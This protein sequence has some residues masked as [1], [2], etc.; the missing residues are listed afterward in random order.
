MKPMLMMKLLMSRE[1]VYAP[2]CV[3][4][5]ERSHVPPRMMPRLSKNAW[6]E[7]QDTYRRKNPTARIDTIAR[8]TIACY[9]FSPVMKSLKNSM[10]ALT[11]REDGC[12]SS[13]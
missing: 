3:R 9:V 7:T 4:K 5:N 11:I 12:S 1:T 13:R 2:N 10:A 6:R 8:T